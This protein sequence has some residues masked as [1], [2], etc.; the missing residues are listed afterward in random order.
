MDQPQRSDPAAG[1]RK[2][3]FSKAGWPG[4]WRHYAV[5]AGCLAMTPA[6]YPS[7]FSVS[8]NGVRA[9]GMGGAFTSVADDAS[10]IFFNPAGIAFQKGLQMEMDSLVVVGLF[11]FFP[12][13]TP[14]GAAV[15]SNGY[16]G[17]VKPHFIPVASMYMTKSVTDRLAIGFGGFAPFGLAA[18][19]TNFNDGDPANTKF[20]GRFAGTRA[21]LQ[22]YWF[23]PTLAYK[24]TPNSALSIGV[25]LV[26]THLFLEQSFLNPNDKPTDFGRSLARDAFPGVDPNQAWAAFARI[27]PEG[28]LRAA[29]TSDAPGFSA[30]YLYKNQRRK[31][32]F[33]ASWRSSVVHH[34]TG[35]ASFAFTNT[36]A[37]TPF[38][39]FDRTLATEFPNQSIKG[40]LV[41]PANYQVGVSTSKFF[42][43]LIAVDFQVQDYQRF[44]DLPINF[45][46]NTDS[47]GRQIGTDPEKRLDFNFTNSYVFHLGMEKHFGKDMELRLGYIYDHSPVPDQS[48]TA[49]FPDSSRNSFTLGATKRRGNMEF[50]LFYQA[51]F[52]MDRVTAVAANNYQFTNGDYNNFAHLCGA[53]MR[54]HLG[55][56]EDTK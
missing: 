16:S 54:M 48:V 11:R 2:Q 40:L 42:N 44:K 27:L 21:A 45:S 1:I 30:G 3:G 18:N 39:P 53:G 12:S 31:F 25:A 9:Q 5:L 29:A 43:T 38:L 47:R 6:A 56:W 33:G 34:L 24:I 23:Q 55:K 32:N 13:A 14:P 15:P 52:F 28:R 26:H 4:L 41:T 19:F 35:K 36:G 37:I 49:L 10:A 46:I 51:M 8:E 50:S 20:V 17:S 7:A 22:S